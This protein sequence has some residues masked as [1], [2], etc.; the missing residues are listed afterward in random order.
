MNPIVKILSVII[1]GIN[2]VLDGMNRRTVDTIKQ[3]F[4]FITAILII[5]G[6]IV[7]YEMGQK[8]AK[9]KGTQIAGST[10]DIFLID[11]KKERATGDFRSMLDS[12]LI[13][14]VR[15]SGINKIEFPS[16]SKYDIETRE[17]IIEPNSSERKVNPPPSLETRDRLSEIE[18]TNDTPDARDVRNLR[19]KGNIKENDTS[20][21]LLGNDTNDRVIKE[22]P[23]GGA[24]ARDRDTESRPTG[25]KKSGP[26][27]LAPVMRQA[28]SELNPIEKNA[29]IIKK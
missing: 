29:G 4:Y 23:L 8:S 1:S 6:A 2:S 19:K 26:E 18:R 9:I 3:G 25:A 22:E 21:E 20:P 28:P 10:N 13:R 5:A 16:N 24:P 27:K 15:E 11:I 7:G 12:E 14:E 17:K